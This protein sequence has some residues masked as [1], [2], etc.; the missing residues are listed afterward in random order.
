MSVPSCLVL[1]QAMS[2]SISAVRLLV[3]KGYTDVNA[4]TT[5]TGLTPLM[6]S[7][8]CRD[9]PNKVRDGLNAGKI[10]AIGH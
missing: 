3:N 4:P 1:M 5:N 6:C 10:A 7:A 9:F 2:G 8:L